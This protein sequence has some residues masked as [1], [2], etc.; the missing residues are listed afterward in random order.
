MRKVKFPLQLDV[1]D[2]TTD[3]LREHLQPVNSAVKQILKKRDDRASIANRAKGKGAASDD[4]S[5]DAY[6]AEERQE[7][8]SLMAASAAPQLGTNPSGIYELCGEEENPCREA[9]AQQ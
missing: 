7:I 9:Y 1:L 8:S 2:I 4:K 3:E 5:E 6:R